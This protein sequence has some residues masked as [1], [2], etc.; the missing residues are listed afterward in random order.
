M[1]TPSPKQAP[2]S[3]QQT[4]GYKPTD[5][6]GATGRF[7]D[8]PAEWNLN[9]KM[10]IDQYNAGKITYGDLQKK[11]QAYGYSSAQLS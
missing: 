4:G 9:V 6:V 5:K 11:L 1:A 8:T 3:P 10:A 2:V 7:D